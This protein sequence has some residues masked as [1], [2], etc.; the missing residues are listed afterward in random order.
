MLKSNISK[1][2][3]WFVLQ[4]LYNIYPKY[5]LY[6]KITNYAG[7]GGGLGLYNEIFIYKISRYLFNTIYEGN[8][9]NKNT[10]LCREYRD[11]HL[12]GP[13]QGIKIIF[14]STAGWTTSHCTLSK[15]VHVKCKIQAQSNIYETYFIWILLA[16]SRSFN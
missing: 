12:K 8:K 2:L 14:V 3:I 5:W 4:Q 11:G 7:R 13:N 1:I 16:G 10:S 15:L 9:M 6:N